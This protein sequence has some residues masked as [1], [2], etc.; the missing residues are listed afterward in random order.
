MIGKQMFAM[1]CRYVFLI[2]K[3]KAV[4]G[5]SSFWYSVSRSVTP[6]LCHPTDYSEP[7]SSVPGVLQARILEWVAI[8]FS[9]TV[10]QRPS[11]PITRVVTFFTTK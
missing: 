5:N 8:S 6:T 2:K 1:P 7:G 11:I 9:K 3:K 10:S 4:S